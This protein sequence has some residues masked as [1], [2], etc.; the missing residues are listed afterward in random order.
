MTEAHIRSSSSSE[1][2][3]SVTVISVVKGSD[4]SNVGVDENE[5]E[6]LPM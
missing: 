4:V 5:R 2:A 1:E 6:T 3:E